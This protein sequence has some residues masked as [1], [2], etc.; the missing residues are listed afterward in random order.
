MLSRIGE[1]EMQQIPPP[2]EEPVEAAPAPEA[3]LAPAPEEPVAPE[4][5]LAPQPQAAPAPAP[6]AADIDIEQPKQPGELHANGIL[7][8]EDFAQAKA[9]A[10]GT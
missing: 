4:P 3:A 6:A 8:D 2:A 1:A 7:S 10:L 5:A 9:T